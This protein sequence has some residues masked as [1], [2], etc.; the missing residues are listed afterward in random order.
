[1][2]C[3]IKLKKVNKNH[4]YDKGLENG[5]N[6]GVVAGLEPLPA[7]AVRGLVTPRP[8]LSPVRLQQVREAFNRRGLAGDGEMSDEGGAVHD[9][10]QHAVHP[11]PSHHHLRH[12]FLNL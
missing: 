11:P 3:I 12:P 2:N 9:G 5:S 6:V 8:G 7:A 1:M 4:T 10:E